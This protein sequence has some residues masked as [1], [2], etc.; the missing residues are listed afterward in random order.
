MQAVTF[1]ESRTTPVWI[2]KLYRL[3]I[4]NTFESVAN[5]SVGTR[6]FFRGLKARIP[7]PTKFVITG[8]SK[9]HTAARWLSKKS[10]LIYAKVRPLEWEKEWKN[11]NCLEDNFFFVPLPVKIISHK[12]IF[13]LRKVFLNK[14]EFT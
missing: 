11:K 6:E 3:V 12:N 1:D 4:L 8:G 14:P 7:A 9:F 5:R 13:L 10:W 2:R